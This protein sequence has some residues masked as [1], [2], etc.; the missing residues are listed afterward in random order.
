MLEAGLVSPRDTNPLSCYVRKGVWLKTET[1]GAPAVAAPRDKEAA[2][3]NFVSLYVEM[4]SSYLQPL[5]WK[6]KS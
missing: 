6:I 2:K 4:L 1:C 3:S 5:Y